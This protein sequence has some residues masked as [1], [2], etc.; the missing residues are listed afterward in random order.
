MRLGNKKLLFAFTVVLASA[1]AVLAAG[2]AS[3]GGVRRCWARLRERQH[4][5][6]EHDRRVRP[7]RRW[8][9]D[10]DASQCAT[11]AA[12]AQVHGGDQSAPPPTREPVYDHLSGRTTSQEER[13]SMP[14]RGSPISAPALVTA[15]ELETA[16]ALGKGWKGCGKTRAQ[17]G[18]NGSM[19]SSPETAST[20][21][22]SLPPPATG[23]PVRAG[24][25]VR[26]KG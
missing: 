3:A 23:C 21:Q 24:N 20:S 13:A 18:A 1:L 22:I 14:E 11:N 17:R 26:L 6:G 10:G 8:D 25:S 16:G 2:G 19:V 15:G 9:A 7:P 5:R 12:P 4:G